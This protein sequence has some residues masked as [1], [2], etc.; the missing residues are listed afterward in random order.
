[1]K[2]SLALEGTVF[3]LYI[4]TRDAKHS[5]LCSDCYCFSCY[6]SYILLF[7]YQGLPLFRILAQF[8]CV[9]SRIKIFVLHL[10]LYILINSLLRG[11]V[12]DPLLLEVKGVVLIS[13]VQRSVSIHLPCHTQLAICL[14]FYYWKTF[15]MPRFTLSAPGKAQLMGNG[16]DVVSSSLS[17]SPP[18]RSTSSVLHIATSQVP[19]IVYDH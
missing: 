3:T 13:H 15:S 14:G 18:P 6:G 1:M 7:L 19:R 16:P 2:P 4:A 9:L 11:W 12:A 8:Y 5:C 17:L 10:I